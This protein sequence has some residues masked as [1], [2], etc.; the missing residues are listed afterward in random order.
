[1]TED[2]EGAAASVHRGNDIHIAGDTH[3]FKGHQQTE[4]SRKQLTIKRKKK[5]QQLE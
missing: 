3:R 2:R 1:M 5:I 4:R